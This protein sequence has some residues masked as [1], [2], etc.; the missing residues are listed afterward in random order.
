MQGVIPRTYCAH[1]VNCVDGRGCIVSFTQK[2]LI[3][4][5]SR[6]WAQCDAFHQHLRI[7]ATRSFEVW[8]YLNHD[9]H[10]SANYFFYKIILHA[11]FAP[12]HETLF[13]NQ[14]AVFLGVFGYI[15]KPYCPKAAL[16]DIAWSHSW[17][18]HG[19]RALFVKIRTSARFG[20]T[21]CLTYRAFPR[22]V[23]TLPTTS[24]QTNHF[25]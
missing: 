2:T 5:T 16:A 24:K 23:F 18:H 6:G 9:W 17:L 3:Q 19:H 13:L 11:D 1:C 25:I 20:R 8:I 15:F 21:F 12:S 22:L 4:R 7:H 10:N 14:C